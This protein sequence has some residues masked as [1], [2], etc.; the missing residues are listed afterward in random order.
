MARARNSQRRTLSAQALV[1]QT[2][3]Q[4]IAEDSSA[5]PLVRLSLSLP[6]SGDPTGL[7]VAYI[8]VGAIPNFVPGT[9]VDPQTITATVGDESIAVWVESSPTLRT[10]SNG[11]ITQR[12]IGL[13]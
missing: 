7:T 4:L 5:F 2:D 9:L 11:R 13:T 6:V 3:A 10:R 8:D 1:P 12:P